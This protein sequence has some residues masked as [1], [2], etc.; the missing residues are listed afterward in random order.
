MSC[1]I[2]LYGPMKAWRPMRQNWW[3]PL[4]GRHVDPILDDDVAGQPHAVAQDDVVADLAIVRHVG[5]GHE[6]VIAA[7]AW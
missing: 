2:T 4:N 7:D 5:V 6:Q 1:L 3:T